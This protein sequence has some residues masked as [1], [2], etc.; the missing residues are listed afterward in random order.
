MDA[1]SSVSVTSA[2]LGSL[3][4]AYQELQAET[5]DSPT[6]QLIDQITRFPQPVPLNCIKIYLYLT[7]S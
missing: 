5:V 6:T 4:V 7:A 1:N 3:G 2:Q